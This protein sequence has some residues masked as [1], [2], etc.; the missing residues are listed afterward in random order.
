MKMTSTHVIQQFIN[1]NIPSIEYEYNVT[2]IWLV[3]S[4][5]RAWGIESKNSD[6]HIR[7]V[8]RYN[9]KQKLKVLTIPGNNIPRVLNGFTINRLI[10][11]RLWEEGFALGHVYKHDVCIYDWLSVPTGSVYYSR[12]GEFNTWRDMRIWN[13]CTIIK[14]YYDLMNLCYQKKVNPMRGPK[15]SILRQ[16]DHI[17]LEDVHI[18]IR[19]AIESKNHADTLRILKSSKK[20]LGVTIKRVKKYIT[21]K[22]EKSR[23]TPTTVNNVWCFLRAYLMLRYMQIF[24]ESAP[25]YYIPAVIRKIGGD[26]IYKGEILGLLDITINPATETSEFVCTEWLTSLYTSMKADTSLLLRELDHKSTDYR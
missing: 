19:Q 1:V 24:P 9:N 2:I 5:S 6:Y 16:H 11:W 7:G 10:G 18:G 13:R 3:E 17:K 14:H 25:I 20:A 12:T 22:N 15:S 26:L 21:S 4:G 23:P 8:F